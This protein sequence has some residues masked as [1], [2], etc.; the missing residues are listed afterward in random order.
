MS[1]K[2]A[3]TSA[4]IT[5]PVSSDDGSY[6]LPIYISDIIK[7]EVDA[8]SGADRESKAISA[9]TGIKHADVY[10]SVSAYES[11]NPADV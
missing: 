7:F 9:Y 4:R 11:G 6:S 8:I 3:D 10:G 1:H 2:A 5:G